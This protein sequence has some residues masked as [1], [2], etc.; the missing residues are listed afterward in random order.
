MADDKQQESI[1]DAIT[2]ITENLTNIVQDEI[3]LAKAEVTQ[4][5]ISI[6]TGA[7][8]VAAGAVVGVFALLFFL[9]TLAWVFNGIFVTGVGSIWLGFL[10]TFVLLFLGTLGVFLFAWK[11]LNVGPPTP[12]MAISEA[13]KVRETVTESANRSAAT[14]AEVQQKKALEASGRSS[15]SGSGG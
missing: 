7:A 10:I 13:K 1:A 2:G 5:V 3:E 12:Q 8:A 15:S 6:A 14:I 4:K 9:I 11:K